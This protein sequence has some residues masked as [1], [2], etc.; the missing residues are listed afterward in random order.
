MEEKNKMGKD[1]TYVE[2]KPRSSAAAIIVFLSILA[3]LLATG[4]ALL[5]RQYLSA[6]HESQINQQQVLTL[7][8]DKLALDRQLIDIDARYSQLSNEHTEMEE[9][10]NTQRQ[11]INQLRTQLRG[12]GG[13]EGVTALRQRIKELE[14][15]LENYRLQVQA[16]EEEKET[17]VGETSQM[18]TTLA[19]TTSRNEQLEAENKD[20]TEQMSKASV[21]TISNLEGTALRERRRGD[22]PTK[23]ARRAAKLRICFN[24]N[25]NLVAD[26]GNKD[27]FIRIINPSNQVYTTSPDNTMEHEGETI[28]YTI[29]RTINYQNDAQ[30]VCEM[31]N[32]DERFQKGYYNVVV[33]FEGQE[34]GYKLFQLE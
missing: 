1:R 20:L 25:Q 27:F 2:N 29:K 19:Q 28:Q 18:R 26:A 33:F 5:L 7:T 14:E 6:R 10:F 15:Q 13:E 34:V 3:I 9:L 17:L 12:G 22:E 31:W 11:Q 24:I 32:Q 30:E 4:G 16:M 8:E 23:S 21:L